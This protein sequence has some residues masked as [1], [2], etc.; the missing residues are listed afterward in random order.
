MRNRL[1]LVLG[2]LALMMSG[3]SAAFADYFEGRQAYLRKNYEEAVK[4]W[5]PLAVEGDRKSQSMLG[6]LY[7]K[8]YGVPQDINEAIKWFRRAAEQG[9]GFGQKELGMAYYAGRGARQDYVRAAMWFNLSK[10]RG[11]GLANRDIVESKM[12][13]RSVQRARRMA[14]E[15]T[16]KHKK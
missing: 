15:W 9:D 13:L 4:N 10:L 5:R 2:V 16:A 11:L 6:Y 14:K 7:K 8:G 12:D 3:S 1:M